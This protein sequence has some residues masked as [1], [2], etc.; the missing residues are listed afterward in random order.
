V[1]NGHPVEFRF[2]NAQGWFSTQNWVFSGMFGFNDTDLSLYACNCPASSGSTAPPTA[3][4]VVADGVTYYPTSSAAPW[5]Y[6]DI[7][8]AAHTAVFWAQCGSNQISSNG[9]ILIDPDGYVF[10]V[11][12]GFDPEQPTVNAISGVTVTAYVSMPEWGGWTPWPAHLYNNQAN[13]Q[14][15]GANGYFAFF[16]PP[17]RYYLQVEGISGYQPWRSPV[18]DVITQVVHLNV[19]Y[20]PWTQPAVQVQL[21]P[22]GPSPAQATI[23]PGQAIAWCA[24]T[25]DQI[26]PHILAQ[27]YTDPQTRPLS[28]LDPI[29]STLAWDGGRLT[30]GQCYRRQFTQPGAYTYTDGLGHAGLITV[31]HIIYL[32]LARKP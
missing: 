32:P 22:E 4:W 16:T 24:T 29:A 15:T 20:T 28:A 31:Q 3:V 12:K 13:P 17:G 10:D 25:N 21:A 2:R 23:L 27:A 14:V 7:T 1:V 18:V 26:P 19:P 30:P 8:G 11:T 5:Y 9:K 6:F